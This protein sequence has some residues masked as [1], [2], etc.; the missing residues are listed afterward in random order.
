MSQRSVFVVF[1]G[2]GWGD[3]NDNRGGGGYSQ[4]GGGYGG[5]GGGGGGGG[6]MRNS[7]SSNVR[8]APYQN[9]SGG[10]TAINIILP[11]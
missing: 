10:K 5:G 6:P 11:Y 4:G 7:Y 8:S 2:G 3:G 9:N 1:S